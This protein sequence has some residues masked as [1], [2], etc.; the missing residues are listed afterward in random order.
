MPH[1]QEFRD[2]FEA[3]CARRGFKKMRKGRYWVIYESEPKIGI[4]RYIVSRGAGF[5]SIGGDLCVEFSSLTPIMKA[6]E[7]KWKGRYPFGQ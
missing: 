6:I 3:Y 1:P 5:T 7:G 4:N 2:Y